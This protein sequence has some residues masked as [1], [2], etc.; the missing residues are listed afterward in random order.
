MFANLS[1]NHYTLVTAASQKEPMESPEVINLL[2]I[3]D[4][5]GYFAIAQHH[6]S[7]YQGRKFNLLWKQDGASALEELER[8]PNINVIL[9]D[10][11]LP[12]IN[13]LEVTRA[14]RSKGIEI[15]IIFLTSNRDFRLA[16]E[17]M[18]Y[19]IGRAHV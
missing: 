6:F 13:G 2:I 17:V 19:E 4:D 1:Q 11:Y 8:N 10:Y 18:K 7:R 14:L 9:I 16:I 15:P 3:D 12:E 5:A